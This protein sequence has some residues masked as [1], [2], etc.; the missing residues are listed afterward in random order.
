MTTRLHL[1][2]TFINERK[3]WSLSLHMCGDYRIKTC[4]RLNAT[5]ISKLAKT[6]FYIF[7]NLNNSDK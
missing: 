5:D 2:S 7:T 6:T 1:L 3:S 4:D